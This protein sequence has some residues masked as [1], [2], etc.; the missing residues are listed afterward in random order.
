MAGKG[1]DVTVGDLLRKTNSTDWIW[2][3]TEFVTPRGHQP[4]ARLVRVNYPSDSRM[5]AIAALRD[6]RLF[7]DADQPRRRI[8]APLPIQ[9]GPQLEA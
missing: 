2:Q 9:W 6:R 7:V 8:E 3:V 5:F 4:H 1:D